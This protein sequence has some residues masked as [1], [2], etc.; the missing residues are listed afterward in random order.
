MKGE[1]WMANDFNEPL[2]DL[3]EYM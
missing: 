2:G 1:V 3:K